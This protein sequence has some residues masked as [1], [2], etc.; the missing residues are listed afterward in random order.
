MHFTPHCI[1]I[2]QISNVLNGKRNVYMS[3]RNLAYT[4][5]MFVSVMPLEEVEG[6]PWGF[7][8]YKD[9]HPKILADPGNSDIK[10]NNKC[11]YEPWGM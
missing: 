1:R 9:L 4:V 2:L 11:R 8:C 5:N 7:L 10:F 3:T 6:H